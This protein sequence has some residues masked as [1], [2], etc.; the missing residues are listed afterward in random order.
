[1][2]VT[3]GTEKQSFIFR[4]WHGDATFSEDLRLRTM[5]VAE[6][7]NIR[8]I[9]EL[10]EKLGAIYGGGFQADVQQ[11]PHPEFSVVMFLPCGPENVDTLVKSSDR[12]IQRLLSE[13]PAASDL[14]KVKSQWR[15]AYKV[16]AKENKWWNDK[17]QNVLFW[18][19]DKSHVL[20][21]EKWIN[22]LTPA[23]VKETAK[24]LFGT[25]NEFTSVLY[26]EK[27]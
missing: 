22:S 17:L 27:S 3:K 4:Q 20:G 14:E 13:G 2:Q 1:M 5:A 7:L 19:H 18:G 15:E 8:V 16:S 21:Y 23:Q 12:E 26:P 9:E 24:M 10:R 11:F 6:I 25:G